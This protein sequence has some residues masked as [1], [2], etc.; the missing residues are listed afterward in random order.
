MRTTQPFAVLLVTFSLLV[1]G[2]RDVRSDLEF[3]AKDRASGTLQ[4]QANPENT[5]PNQ[6]PDPSP[7]E[8]DPK[9]PVQHESDSGTAPEKNNNN[10]TSITRT[11]AGSK[12]INGSRLAN[13]YKQEGFRDRNSSYN[14]FL[15]ANK[16][17]R[18]QLSGSF[19]KQYVYLILEK[20]GNNELA[21]YL[22][23]GKG[24]CTY[25]YGEWYRGQLQVYDPSKGRLNVIV[26]E[27]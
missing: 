8:T 27:K 2:F 10:N 14:S 25:V 22:Y 1:I 16:K 19:N 5:Q 12:A 11:P 13:S 21:G 6:V 9:Q 20:I 24:G 4:D 26:Y 7:D 3:V 15:K 17:D 23:D 18:I